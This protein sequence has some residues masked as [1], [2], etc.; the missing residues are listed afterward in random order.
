M[1]CAVLILLLFAVTS[2]AQEFPARTAHE[3]QQRLRPQPA[4][5]S[6]AP[7][8]PIRAAQLRD[9]V[10][11]HVLFGYHPY[12]IADSVTLHYDF[13]LL[14]HLAYFSA[15][16]DPATGEMTTV[17]GW[18][19]VPVLD[20]AAAAG[21]KVQ[22]AVT[23]FGAANNRALLSS[24][25]ARDTLV[26]RIVSL[27]RQR[28]ADG[29]SIDFEAVPG[30][31]R[32]NLTAF[33]AALDA[34]LAA[35]LPDAEISAAVPAV[36]WNDA[37][38]L[39]ALRAH[40]DLFFL[41]GYDYFWSGSGTAGPVAPIRGATYNVQRSL[42]D[43]L[44]KGVPPQRLLLGVPYYGYDWP[45]V[46]GAEGA[47]TTGR[48]VARTWSYVQDMSG[49]Q[50]RQWST[51]Y[52][53]PWFSYETANWRQVWFDDS[54][55]LSEKY[56]LVLDRSLAGVGIW[57]LGYDGSASALRELLREK[58]TRV[59]AVQAPPDAPETLALHAFPQPLRSGETLTLERAGETRGGVQLRITDMLGRT[60]WQGRMEEGRISLRIALPSLSSGMYSLVMRSGAFRSVRPLL[61]VR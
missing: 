7:A 37:W 35:A 29:V 50:Q 59:T 28:D 20:R 21:V 46:S 9:R 11:T 26:R 13:S 43:Y 38:D 5:V 54:E 24:Q 22:L 19:A 33:F 12:W 49:L 31:Q 52:A 10:R 36:D 25:S 56:D 57:A 2:R 40:I 17:R 18:P 61:I 51:T 3:A 32:E 23:N 34:A 41:M 1:R 39:E 8:A 6:A 58:F 45:V 15:E 4:A 14:S 44:Q 55:S 60:R 48:A 27:L 47:A 53:N 42:D 30:D 16:V